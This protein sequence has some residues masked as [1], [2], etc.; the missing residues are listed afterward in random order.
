MK[1]CVSPS[2]RYDAQT[3]LQ[4]PW[5]TRE[6]AKIPMTIKQ[7][8]QMFEAERDLRKVMRLAF[9]LSHFKCK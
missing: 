6:E 3:A 7:E 8:V 5:I 4:H 2:S 9:F 1:L